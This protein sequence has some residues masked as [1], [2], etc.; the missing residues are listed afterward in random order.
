MKLIK[1]QKTETVT[2]FLDDSTNWRESIEVNKQE[3]NQS[4][5]Y[6][7]EDLREVLKSKLPKEYDEDYIDEES[8]TE[9][10]RKIILGSDSTNN[11]KEEDYFYDLGRTV[12]DLLPSEENEEER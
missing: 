7:E 10:D 1:T 3:E 4:S 6:Q 2:S 5:N 12:K 11:Q 9:E 8:I